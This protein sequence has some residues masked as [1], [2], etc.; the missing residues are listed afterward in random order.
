MKMCERSEAIL[1]DLWAIASESDK[2]PEIVKPGRARRQEKIRKITES[3][4]V[5]SG[6]RAP[7]ETPVHFTVRRGSSHTACEPKLSPPST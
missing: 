1:G 3:G 6:G 5:Q 4:R 2:L 7:G